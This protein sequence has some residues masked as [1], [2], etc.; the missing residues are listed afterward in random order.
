MRSAEENLLCC[1]SACLNAAPA[2]SSV[3]LLQDAHLEVLKL[4]MTPAETSSSQSQPH[5]LE[6]LYQS[7]GCSE[8]MGGPV[9]VLQ[10]ESV[11]RK[12]TKQRLEKFEFWNS[13]KDMK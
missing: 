5:F 3:G 8:K 1:A 10:N 12:K 4:L 11:E 9:R 7:A 13:R 2:Q 6:V